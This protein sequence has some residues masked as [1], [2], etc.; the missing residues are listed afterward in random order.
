MA[1]TKD[2]LVEELTDKVGNTILVYLMEA[3]QYE[4]KRCIGYSEI[5]GKIGWLMQVYLREYNLPEVLGD[6]EAREVAGKVVDDLSVEFFDFWMRSI[7]E[8]RG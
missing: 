5:K 7:C 4:G 2:E 8:R 3:E 1:T 6:N